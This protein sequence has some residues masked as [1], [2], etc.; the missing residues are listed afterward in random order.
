MAR[1]NLMKGFQK[2]KP[3]IVEHSEETAQYGKFI[4][5]P[6]E[7][8]F[9][10]TIGNTLRRILLSSIQG[11]AISAIRITSYDNEGKAH[12]IS[13]EFESIPHIVED[14]PEIVNNLKKLSLK[15]PED[16]EQKT[17]LIE[18][19][20]LGQLSGADFA[21]DGVEVFNADKV[22]ATL[23]DEANLDIEVQIDLNR[24]YVPSEINEKYIET[25][26]TIPVD[27]IYSPITRVKYEVEN[28][29]VGQR[30]DY[31]KLI[32]EIWSDGTISPADALGE[33]GKIAKDF[34][35]MFINFDEDDIQ[36]D[37]APDEE[38]AYIQEIL[39]TPVEELELSVRS[40][41]CLKNANIK[42]IGDL[43]RRT[44][45][46]IAKTRN[47]GKKSLS[48]IKEKLKER[49]LSLGMTDYTVLKK[50]ITIGE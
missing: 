21:I 27:A 24:G 46:E 1:K 2:P 6:F 44:E 22:I 13:S 29:R 5:S 20:G 40:S 39:N 41:N 25:V 36:S 35:S 23:M 30:A 9:G 18:K 31:D 32:I 10:T 28:T 12:V 15:L 4:V 49:N 38:E 47:F 7:R 43:T 45:E 34:F 14:T 33:A 16:V 17:I 50:S 42:T 48:E 19:K 37:S 11:Y 26:G 8:G 3:I